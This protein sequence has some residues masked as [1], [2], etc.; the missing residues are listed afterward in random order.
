MLGEKAR[1]ALAAT[2][3]ALAAARRARG[4]SSMFIRL[5]LDPAVRALGKQIRS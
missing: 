3:R 2:K 1:P 4:D 5:A